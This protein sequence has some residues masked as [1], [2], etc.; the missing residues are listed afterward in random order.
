MSDYGRSPLLL[1]TIG[2][3]SYSFYLRP[4]YEALWTTL[5]EIGTS[6]ALAFRQKLDRHLSALVILC[7][8]EW[9]ADILGPRLRSHAPTSLA[10]GVCSHERGV[11][12]FLTQEDHY[13]MRDLIISA[14]RAAGVETEG[15]EVFRV[16]PIMRMASVATVSPQLQAVAD[17]DAAARD[18]SKTLTTT[19]TTTSNVFSINPRLYRVADFDGKA[20]PPA[21]VLT[22][23]P[24]HTGDPTDPTP[25][26]FEDI[27]EA[28][29]LDPDITCPDYCQHGA[30]EGSGEGAVPWG[31]IIVGVGVL[32]T[33]G[34]LIS[35]R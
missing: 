11:G 26:D 9:P 34:Y 15:G 27:C 16:T 7:R 33:A 2:S 4:E 29:L 35:R 22:G 5:G 13:E 6:Q 14:E 1:G 30:Q 25:E 28:C 21:P 20:P 10:V 24:L 31:W 32:G 12:S 18:A 19:T 17:A 8:G 23:D 3:T